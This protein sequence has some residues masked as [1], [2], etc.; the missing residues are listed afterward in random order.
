VTLSK[1]QIA[2]IKDRTAPEPGI[3]RDTQWR[4]RLEIERLQS[5]AVSRIPTLINQH[6]WLAGVTLYWAEGAKSKN[7][8]SM[9][10]ADPAALRLFI[11]WIRAYINSDARFSIQ[12][13]LH[14]GN[15]EAAARSYWRQETGL[16]AA[17]SHKTYIKPKGTGHRKNHLPHGIC[18]VRVRRCSDGWHQTIAW[19]GALGPHLGV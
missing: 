15:D 7:Q 12:L 1:E 2:A 10:N 9:A 19:I 17:N 13:H 18:T 8:L 6:L 4:R 11:A 14:E 5:E 3:P 16:A